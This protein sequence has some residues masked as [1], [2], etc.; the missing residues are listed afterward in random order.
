MHKFSQAQTDQVAIKMKHKE[1]VNITLLLSKH[2]R[3]QSKMQPALIPLEG[4]I[5]CWD[6]YVLSKCD[7]SNEEQMLIEQMLISIMC[8]ELC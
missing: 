4:A 3:E 1:D 8:Q 5:S 2:E 7:H 6:N